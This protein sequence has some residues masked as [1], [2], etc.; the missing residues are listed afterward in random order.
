MTVLKIIFVVL[1]CFP[2][3]YLA[4]WL[5]GQLMRHLNRT[6]H[7]DAARRDAGGR[8]RRGSARA[9]RKRRARARA[10]RR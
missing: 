3:A 8:D 7:P 5:Y 1:L 4:V 9:A 6:D 10:A 2:L